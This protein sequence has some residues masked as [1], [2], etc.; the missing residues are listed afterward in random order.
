MSKMPLSD[1][2]IGLHLPMFNPTME[3]ARI[4]L[5]TR[6]I[7]SRPLKRLVTPILIVVITFKLVT[8][9]TKGA[10]VISVAS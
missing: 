4:V 3:Q 8:A 5:G 2:L 10:V 1:F 9:T 6:G 7:R